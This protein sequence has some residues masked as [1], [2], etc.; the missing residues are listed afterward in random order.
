MNNEQRLN[1]FLTHIRSVRWFGECGKPVTRWKQAKDWSTAC[2]YISEAKW[3]NFTLE[4]LN[5]YRDILWSRI[6]LEQIPDFESAWNDRADFINSQVDAI[7]SD[8]LFKR[9]PFEDMRSFN[10]TVRKELR[11]M[12]MEADN[13]DIMEPVFFQPLLLQVY[14]SGHLPCGW[15]GDLLPQG[16]QGKSLSDLPSGALV[17][18]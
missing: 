15:S 16:W 11:C 6:P 13:S 12:A 14:E 3:Q 2:R 1:A 10:L 5:R 18:F 9:L 4:L 17:V 8:Q 7:C